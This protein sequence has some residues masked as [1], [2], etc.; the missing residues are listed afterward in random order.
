[1]KHGI[2]IIGTAF[3]SGGGDPSVFQAL[4]ESRRDRRL[5]ASAAGTGDND[6]APGQGDSFCPTI[7][8]RRFRS[9]SVFFT[10]GSF[11]SSRWR[12]RPCNAYSAMDTVT[13]AKMAIAIAREGLHPFLFFISAC[14]KFFHFPSSLYFPDLRAF[15]MPF[16]RCASPAAAPISCGAF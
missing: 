1:M 8:I 15:H 14:S 3:K 12:Q 16:G 13:E 11:S 6:S 9:L 4:K 10:H 5:S 2:D 7:R